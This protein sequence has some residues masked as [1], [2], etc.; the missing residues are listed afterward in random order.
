MATFLWTH[1]NWT[2]GLVP[3]ALRKVG[4]MGEGHSC[5]KRYRVSLGCQFPHHVDLQILAAVPRGL[6]CVRVLE[7]G[8]K[9]PWWR[10][11]QSSLGRGHWISAHSAGF[12]AALGPVPLGHAPHHSGLVVPPAPCSLP[13]TFR[14]FQV[15][16]LLLFWASSD[17]PGSQ[18]NGRGS[19]RNSEISSPS[20]LASGPELD[21][22]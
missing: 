22:A 3:L 19:Q 5:R 6:P 14:S 10:S 16:E 20:P 7:R 11:E 17:S 2:Q 21:L 4:S 1:R 13:R 15:G 12:W 8:E 18:A 9:R